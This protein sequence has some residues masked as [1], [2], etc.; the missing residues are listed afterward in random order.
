MIC[1]AKFSF[2]VITLHSLLHLQFSDASRCDADAKCCNI[3]PMLHLHLAV[4]CS[5]LGV[6]GDSPRQGEQ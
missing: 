2:F 4:S 5:S 3:W 6:V 1:K